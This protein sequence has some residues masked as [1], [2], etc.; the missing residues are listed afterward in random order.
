MTLQNPRESTVGA[1]LTP[2]EAYRRGVTAQDEA[3][4]R[5]ADH[6]D[7]LAR[8]VERLVQVRMELHAALRFI[9]RNADYAGG[10]G[11]GQEALQRLRMV[12]DRADEALNDS[13]RLADGMTRDPFADVPEGDH[14]A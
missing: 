6:R 11:G 2:D 14:D 3:M 4:V 13:Y 5:L 10:P 8:Q 7:A 9:S 1:K 12:R